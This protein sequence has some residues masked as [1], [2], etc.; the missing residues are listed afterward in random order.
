MIRFMSCRRT[1][2]LEVNVVQS[3]PR[4][5]PC[6]LVA[7]R[8]LS[9]M[10]GM[11]HNLYSNDVGAVQLCCLHAA[12]TAISWLPCVYITLVTC[13]ATFLALASRPWSVPAAAAAS[14]C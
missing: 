10:H 1:E 11:T 8:L 14:A 2:H 9:G 5:G 7:G 3:I 4:E 13:A 12:S 6:A